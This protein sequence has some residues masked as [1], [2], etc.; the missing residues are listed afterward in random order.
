MFLKFVEQE[1]SLSYFLLRSHWTL[2][3]TE[4]VGLITSQCSLTKAKAGEG[5]VGVAHLNESVGF[6]VVWRGRLAGGTSWKFALLSLADSGTVGSIAAE[7]SLAELGDGVGLEKLRP[8]TLRADT[9]EKKIRTFK[10]IDWFYTE[11][12]LGVGTGKPQFVVPL[13]Y[14]VIGCFLYVRWPEIEPTTLVYGD[15][16]LTN[17]ST[18]PGRKAVLLEHGT[19]RFCWGIR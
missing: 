6:R 4:N 15:D 14:P 8:A 10:F 5:R 16:A 13:S 18:Q 3:V 19:F 2:S 11:R 7:C 1:E 12:G 17:W 9:G